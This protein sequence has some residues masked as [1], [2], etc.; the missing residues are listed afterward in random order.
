MANIIMIYKIPWSPAIQTTCDKCK[1]CSHSS[2]LGFSQI[3]FWKNRQWHYLLMISV[4][5]YLP[6]SEYALVQSS[7]NTMH[8]WTITQWINEWDLYLSPWIYSDR[9]SGI[10]WDAVYRVSL[11]K[12]WD[13]VPRVFAREAK[14][15]HKKPFTIWLSTTHNLQNQE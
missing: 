5:C 14:V 9:D 11:D 8:G 2:P 4:V 3:F 1:I 15:W 10:G 6:F 12:H 7:Y 13:M